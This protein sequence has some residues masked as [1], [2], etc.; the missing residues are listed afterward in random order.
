[1]RWS[2]VAERRRSGKLR[3]FWIGPYRVYW[4]GWHAFH[5]RP[6][7]QDSWAE[8]RIYSVAWLGFEFNYGPMHS[9]GYNI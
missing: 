2:I 4:H 9:P 6:L 3:G 7:Y 8:A 1:M 5:W